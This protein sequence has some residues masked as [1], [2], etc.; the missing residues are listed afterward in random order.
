MI[1]FIFGTAI[2]YICIAHAYKIAFGSVTN[3]SNYGKSFI[4]LC[5]LLFDNAKLVQSGKKNITGI[6]Q[7]ADH[8]KMVRVPTPPGN[9]EILGN[10]VIMMDLEIPWNFKKY[11]KKWE[12]SLKY[13][14]IERLIRH[15][16]LK[17]IYFSKRSCA[18]IGQKA[19]DNWPGL[20]YSKVLMNQRLSCM[21]F[22][23]TCGQLYETIFSK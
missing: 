8:R 4:R 16:C 13:L 18:V 2:R 14:E 20:L 1:L 10:L 12:N 15:T 6:F 21:G 23:C 9:R 17:V 5:L 3:L 7:H 11:V 19:L 22:F